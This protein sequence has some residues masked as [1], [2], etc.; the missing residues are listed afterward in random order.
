MSATTKLVFFG[1]KAMV[2]Y[3]TITSSLHQHYA[4]ATCCAEERSVYKRFSFDN[5]GSALSFI[6]YLHLSW[7]VVSHPRCAGCKKSHDKL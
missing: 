1:V 3:V 7:C 2:G 6:I 5:E 4:C